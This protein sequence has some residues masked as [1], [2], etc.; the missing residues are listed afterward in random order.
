M[1]RAKLILDS[2]NKNITPVKIKEPQ[3]A[4]TKQEN[5]TLKPKY[6]RDKNNPNILHPY[7]MRK[8]LFFR[9]Y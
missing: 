9:I 8:F 4:V 6:I 3:K 7:K 2:I 1:K 5:T